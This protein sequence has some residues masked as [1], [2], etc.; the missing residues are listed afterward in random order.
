MINFVEHPP[1]TQGCAPALLNVARNIN[2]D[3]KQDAII[4]L[5]AVLLLTILRFLQGKL[6][7]RYYLIRRCLSKQDTSGVKSK[8]T[9]SSIKAFQI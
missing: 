3:A 5:T 6:H 7:N 4:Y 1:K 9:I 2:N 8:N